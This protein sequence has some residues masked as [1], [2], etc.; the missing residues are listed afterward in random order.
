MSQPQ[1]VRQSQYPSNFVRSFGNPGCC[2]WNTR[3]LF[4]L[5]N[6]SSSRALRQDVRFIRAG[7][8]AAPPKFIEFFIESRAAPRNVKSL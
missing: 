8:I 2:G 3:T 7:R 1:H 4:L 6:S 5:R